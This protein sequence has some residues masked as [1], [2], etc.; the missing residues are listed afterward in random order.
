[1]GWKAIIYISYSGPLPNRV[2]TILPVSRIFIFAPNVDEHATCLFSRKSKCGKFSWQYIFVAPLLPIRIYSDDST[3]HHN[4]YYIKT[5]QYTGIYNHK[6]L[7]K[8]T[9]DPDCC[10]FQMQSTLYKLF[11]LLLNM[12]LMFSLYK[13]FLLL[14]NMCLMFSLYKLFLLLLNMCLMFSLSLNVDK[15][16]QNHF[17]SC[18]I[19]SKS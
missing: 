14:L 17:P 2:T 19:F 10:F 15:P 11:L 5:Y 3:Q 4:S 12:C 8:N 1:M 18:C 16:I 13:L 6:I 9:V 7:I